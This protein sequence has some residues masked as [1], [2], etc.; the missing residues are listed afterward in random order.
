M[1]NPEIKTDCFAY[2]SRRKIC[3]VLTETVC[4]NRECTFYKTQEQ[5]DSDRM[6]HAKSQTTER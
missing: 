4:K 3:S 6:K 1:N 5:F 2:H